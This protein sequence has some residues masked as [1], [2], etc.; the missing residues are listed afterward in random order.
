MQFWDWMIIAGSLVLLLVIIAIVMYALGK[1]KGIQL[2]YAEPMK[3]KNDEE[4]IRQYI[5]TLRPFLPLRMLG[6]LKIIER[7]IPPDKLCDQRADVT[8]TVM[9]GGHP[10]TGSIV[11]EHSTDEIYDEINKTLNVVFP[12]IADN[13]GSLEVVKDGLFRVLFLEEPESAL[14]SAI[15][16]MDTLKDQSI[17]FGLTY[18]LLSVGIVGNQNRMQIITLSSSAMVGEMLRAKAD[19]YYANILSTGEYVKQIRE[20]DKK[21]NSRFLG[22]LYYNDSDQTDEI[23]DIFDGDPVE[24]RNR[25]RKTKML[26]EKGVRLYT[27]RRFAE[28]RGYFIEVLKAD[29]EDAAARHYLFLCDT[30]QK[31]DSEKAKE[32]DICLLNL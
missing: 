26:F 3:R 23:Y 21:F 16:A 8:A 7:E 14:R 15:L 22:I 17:S 18:G 9:C 5:E 11:T 31:L 29:H 28:S 2:G 25:K 10:V 20:F 27:E 4:H 32:V 24:R 19:E 30:Y 12:A 13:H 1:R 6:D